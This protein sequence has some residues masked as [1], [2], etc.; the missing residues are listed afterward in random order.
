MNK[1]YP[2]EIKLKIIEQYNEG[3]AVATL[4]K[5]FGISKSSIYSWL[6]IDLHY[7]L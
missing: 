6:K 3:K 2:I 1:K 5:E 4:S 7:F